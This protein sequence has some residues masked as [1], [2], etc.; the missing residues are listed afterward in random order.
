MVLHIRNVDISSYFLAKTVARIM[1]FSDD[2]HKV[3]YNYTIEKNITPPY[4]TPIRSP[5]PP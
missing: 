5:R 1:D 4:M 2:N 3:L